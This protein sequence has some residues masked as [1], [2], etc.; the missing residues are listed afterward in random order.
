MR[1]GLRSGVK[2]EA[3]RDSGL[4]KHPKTSEAA[5]AL[6]S[7]DS[8]GSG[9]DGGERKRRRINAGDSNGEGGDGGNV[10]EKAAVVRVLRSGN[11]MERASRRK[12]RP[13]PPPPPSPPLQRE[14]VVAVHDD[15]TDAPDTGKHGD[16]DGCVEEVVYK[17]VDI[18]GNQ[19]KRKRG[20]PFGS[21]SKSKLNAVGGGGE[22][23]PKPKLGSPPKARDNADSGIIGIKK[24]KPGSP[25]NAK[26]GVLDVEHGRSMG[27][28][29]QMKKPK[30]GRPPKI[31]A[32]VKSDGQEE[33]C[34]GDT[35]IKKLK[36]G[37]GRPPKVVDKATPDNVCKDAGTTTSLPVKKAVKFVSAQ[38]GNLGSNE[39]RQEGDTPKRNASTHKEKDGEKM[40]STQKQAVRNK[41][42]DLLLAA[43]W[44]IQHRPR[45][46][47]D[48]MDAVY[49][50][51]E[52]KTHWSVTLA[53]RVLK[54]HYEGGGAHSDSCQP[55]FKFTPLPD[56]EIHMLAKVV[57]KTR[58]DKDK[59]KKKLSKKGQIGKAGEVTGKKKKKQKMHKAI[60]RLRSSPSDEDD[61][62]AIF[63]KEKVV[64]GRKARE[65][66]GRKGYSLMIRPPKD[67]MESGD[68]YV[69]YTGKRSV[70]SWMIDLGTVAVDGYI[71]YSKRRKA[72]A[73]RKGRITMDGI[74]CD[75][76]GQ[77]F[78]IAGFEAHAG[79][80]SCQPLKNIF[81]EN[82]PSLLQCLLDTWY[83]QD[84]YVRKGFHLVDING[85][86]PNDDTCG[87]CGDGGDLICCD[88]CPSTFHQNCLEIE[89]G[90]YF[91]SLSLLLSLRLN[92]YIPI[93]DF[94]AS[95]ILTIKFTSR[96]SYPEY[97][98]YSDG[99]VVLGYGRYVLYCLCLHLFEFPSGIWHCIYCSCKFCGM[100]DGVN[101]CQTDHDNA[102]PI[103]ALHTCCMCEEKCIDYHQSCV[104]VLDDANDGSSSSSFCGKKCQEL[105]D[106]IQMLLGVRHELEEGF[107]WAFVR[108]FDIGSPTDIALRGMPQ[109]I[110]CNSK[111]AVASSVMDEC[112]LPMEDNRSGVNLIRNIVYNFGQA[113]LSLSLCV[114]NFN[115]LNYGSFLTAILERGDE[116]VAAASIRIHGNY[117]A[118]MPFIGTRH[119]YRRQ[120]MCRRLLIGIESALCSLNVEKLVIPAIS[121]LRE[122]WTSVFGFKP[123]GGLKQR[124]KNMN[125]MVFPGVDM[126]EK[127]VVKHQ[128]PC[129]HTTHADV[130]ESL[131][132]VEH[133]AIMKPNM[134]SGASDK[135]CMATDKESDYSG[136]DK[137]GVH[138]PPACMPSAPSDELCRSADKSSDSS[139]VDKNGVHD[140]E[141]LTIEVEGDH[142]PHSGSLTSEK[143]PHADSEVD[144]ATL[145]K[146]KAESLCNS[147]SAPA[148]AL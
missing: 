134:L 145:T 102:V 118:E 85:E 11:V 40:R 130:V 70:L 135:F 106:R 137:D 139:A 111:V 136:V 100:V 47:R 35:P 107:T 13:L 140:P 104:Q 105:H 132:V 27:M 50:N 15:D 124:M 29:K 96:T 9:G 133:G 62:A 26:S 3:R 131:K 19:L 33:A 36:P 77:L 83:K 112:F 117:L 81:L 16:T 93:L 67:G 87:M 18:A 82:G 52:G 7:D 66:L 143:R 122:T 123:L 34:D 1:K 144:H 54:E 22:M 74:Q 108:R 42:V 128:P 142:S 88:T 103:S 109:K 31:K 28:R 148:V 58:S 119:M 97:E 45:A 125:M 98:M 46:G 39:T 23:K 80:K 89:V 120:G 38:D 6:V 63:A 147:S 71:Q 57:G 2:A 92:E 72:S 32:E 61:S 84:E 17:G 30:R 14:D 53:Y 86:D 10:V 138:D 20:R 99:N 121:E 91:L 90:D 73:V 75:C 56:E 55:G 5:P 69:L 115:R 48:Y 41:I 94:N 114:S 37:R 44:S 113:S 95:C 126:L 8:D 24:P 78:S 49:V 146:C 101:A 65:T 116:I 4:E 59:K 21:G 68:G 51:P 76:C 64:S 60:K 110:E 141:R 79:S 12:K 127:E 25:P 129:D 43:G